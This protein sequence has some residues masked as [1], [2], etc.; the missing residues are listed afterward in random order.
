MALL[1][2]VADLPVDR[3]A[4]AVAHGVKPFSLTVR[5]LQKGYF[6]GLYKRPA[7]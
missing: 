4:S 1:S 3:D 2:Y 6:S 7:P 5:C